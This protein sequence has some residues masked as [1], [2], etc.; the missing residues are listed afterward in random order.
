MG[1]QNSR[2]ELPL[3][4]WLRNWFLALGAERVLVIS[5]EIRRHLE[6]V[7]ASAGTLVDF[8]FVGLDLEAFR[9]EPG[10]HAAV[11]QEFGFPAAAPLVSTIGALHPRK[12]HELFIDAAA[13][14]VREEPATCFL[15]I[16]GGELRRDLERRARELGLG[17]RLAFAGVR[18]DLARLLTATDVYVKPGV[19]EGFIGI[20]VLQALALGR[21]VV[22]FETEDVKLAVQD[23]VTGL[24]VP[25]ADTAALAERV[26]ALLRQPQLGARL[27]EQ[28]Q[29][30]VRERFHFGVLAERLERFYEQLV[31]RTPVPALAR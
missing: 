4:T 26:V 27:G 28:G 25:N 23:G 14:I 11:R 6:R 24:L 1:L 9:G 2:D 8:N 17:N 31:A 19:L 3:T 30:L 16:G 29:Q 15:V 13:R 5:P 22:A 12:S 21:P 20:T 7:G 18:N 10:D